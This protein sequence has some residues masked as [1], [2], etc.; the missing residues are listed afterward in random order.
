MD[1]VKYGVCGVVGGGRLLRGEWY[2][3]IYVGY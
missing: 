3:E 2:G 1:Y